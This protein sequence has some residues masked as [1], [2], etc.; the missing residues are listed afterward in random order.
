MT[1]VR[2]KHAQFAYRVPF[3]ED[4]GTGKVRTVYGKRL[5]LHD[6]VVD[7]P[8][9]EDIEFGEANN[10]FYT[11]AD[12][13]AAEEAAAETE[14]SSTEHDDLVAWIRDDR[15]NSAEVVAAAGDDPEK[16]EAL[17]AAENEASGGDPRKSVVEPLGKIAS[18]G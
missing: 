2:I 18:Q 7:I 16:A 1:E 9:D 12:I 14:P 8:L 4:D 17:I 5:A 11:E 3:E 15:P 10:A 13:E 6:E